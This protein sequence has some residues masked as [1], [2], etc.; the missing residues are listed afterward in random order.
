MARI[1]LRKL[2]DSLVQRL[3]ARAERNGRSL[4]AEVREIL[5]TAATKRR[6]E[7]LQAAAAMRA[8]LAGRHHTGTLELLREDRD[9]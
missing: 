4:D 3:K 8:R 2:P 7:F 1:L 6:A 5:Q 9:R